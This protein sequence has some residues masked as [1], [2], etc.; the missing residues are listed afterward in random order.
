MA[1]G[2]VAFM[3]WAKVVLSYRYT[4]LNIDLSIHNFKYRYTGT[5]VAQEKSCFYLKKKINVFLL[6]EVLKRTNIVIGPF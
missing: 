4:C 3:Q 5:K 2:T 1:A 6:E